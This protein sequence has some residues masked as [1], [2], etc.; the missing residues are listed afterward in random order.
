MTFCTLVR[1]HIRGSSVKF[2]SPSRYFILC[3]YSDKVKWMEAATKL[4]NFHE[5]QGEV[6]KVWLLKYKHT[7]SSCVFDLKVIL[8]NSVLSLSNPST[9][10]LNLFSNPIG[11]K[12]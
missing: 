6:I 2:A 3:V 8:F 5:N 4:A 7:K 10:C 12:P 9:F 11:T 1:R